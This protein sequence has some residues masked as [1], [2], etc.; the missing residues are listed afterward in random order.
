MTQFDACLASSPYAERLKLAREAALAAGDIQKAHYGKP[1]EIETKSSGIDLVTKVDLACDEAIQGFIRHAYPDDTLI[2]EETFPEATPDKQQPMADFSL[3]SAWIVDP[4]DGT[5]NFA[6]SFPHF[7]VSIAYL[8]QG[9]PVVG[10]VYD[11]LKDE[12]FMA[13]KGCGA[14]LEKPQTGSP[15]DP[16][17]VSSVKML[18][19]ALL[20]TGFPYDIATNPLNNLNYLSAMLKSCHG[21]RR[22]GA[23][24]LDLAYVAAGRLDGFW[25][26][27]LSPWDLAAGVLLVEEAGGAC[28]D[29][30]ASQDDDAGLNY[31]RR[32]IDIASA[33]SSAVL[34]QI[35][36]VLRKTR[37]E[38][39][40]AA[41]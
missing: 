27:T 16:I 10:V 19:M 14:Y 37:Q 12:L 21:V 9:Q 8:S 20:A 2:S 33:N 26:I 4:L 23:A 5:T 29:A 30:Y 3:E 32:R 34:A 28:Q 24:A 39:M 6:H 22:P 15:A 17:S 11:V 25:E 40:A 35:Q 7:A 36:A 18:D 41:R 31:G 1:I 38:T 13:L